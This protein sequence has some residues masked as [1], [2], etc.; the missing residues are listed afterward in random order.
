[1]WL[2]VA[3]FAAIYIATCFFKK[4]VTVLGFAYENDIIRIK[5][6]SINLQTIVVDSVN[7]D[8]K[9][10][11]NFYKKFNY[12]TFFR[13]KDLHI[14]IDSGNKK[15]LDTILILPDKNN[16]PLVSFENPTETK[17]KRRFFIIDQTDPRFM[18]Y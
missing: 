13:K 18:I 7:Q 12:Y 16:K 1:M 5:Q 17:F 6:S 10:V 15:L 2:S 4:E 3:V 8:T 14:E 9:H 11:C